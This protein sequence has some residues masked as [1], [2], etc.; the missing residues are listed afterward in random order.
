[1]KPEASNR[2]PK[3]EG[4]LLARAQDAANKRAISEGRDGLHNSF[5]NSKMN[6]NQ[7]YSLSELQATSHEN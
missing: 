1:M 7:V 5:S 3:G 6:L 2:H 4:K